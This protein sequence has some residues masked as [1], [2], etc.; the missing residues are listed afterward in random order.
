[1]KPSAALDANRE[2]VRAIVR[3]HHASNPRVFGSA[4]TGSDSTTSDLDL[5]IDPTQET[6]LLDIGAIRYEL[7]E[8]LGV[9]V[10]VITPNALPI[11]FR[12]AVLAEAVPV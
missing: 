8:L 5:L 3:A 6:T 2:A 1:M 9:L 12:D 11:R 7:I 4:S 10:D